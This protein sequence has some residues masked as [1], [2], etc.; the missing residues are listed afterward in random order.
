MRTV[1]T[2]SAVPLA[3]VKPLEGLISYRAYC[4]EQTRAA[5]A[6]GSVVRRNTS[7]IDGAPLEPF[8][9]VD[10][11]DYRRCP[12]TGSLFLAQVAQPAAW[13]AL[14]GTVV[15]YRHS[16]RAF[17][18]GIA[19]SRTDTVYAPKLEWIEHTLRL[20]E[21]RRPR[22]L[23][24]TTAPS[25]FTRL[26]EESGL[27][28]TVVPLDEMALMA[29]SASSPDAPRGEAAVL[30]ESLD[31]VPDPAA[32]LG[33]V[34]ERLTPGGLI[35]AT[36]LVASG[37][38]VAVLGIRNLYLYPPDR[39]NCFT[40][41]GLEALVTR[42][43]LSLVEVS[44]PGMLD[45]EIVQAHVRR[46]PSVTLSAFE[47]QLVDVDAEARESVQAFLQQQGLS[48]FARLVARKPS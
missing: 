35:F 10:G 32:L 4:L 41:T 6:G 18:A 14:L 29:S 25:D 21:R 31:R 38:D 12:R 42:A 28:S 17:H 27:C 40:L 7:P 44:T 37:F 43:G 1:Q 16:P 22:V 47:R 45:V 34:V 20:H 5:L 2:G 23:E 19:Q 3:A 8:G 9:T 33:H 48:S 39:T 26:L 46:D 36:G 24:I 13:A 11:L 30:L 15:R